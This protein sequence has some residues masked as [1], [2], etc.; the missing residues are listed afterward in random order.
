M[1]IT[2]LHINNIRNHTTTELEPDGELN[3]FYGLNGS[4]KTSVIEAISICGFTKSFMPCSDSSIIREGEESYLVSCKAINDYEIPYHVAV[5]YSTGKKKRINSTFGDNLNPKDIIGE[6]P[7]VILNPDYKMITFG[8][9]SDRRE[10]LD[11]LLSQAGKIYMEELIKMKKALKQRNSLLS[12]AKSGANVDYS[13]IEPWNDV[14][15]KSAAEI[16]IRRRNFIRDFIPY[17]QDVYNTIAGE[18][19]E[20][21]IDYLPDSLEGIDIN[22]T[23]P[24]EIEQIY[25]QKLKDRMREEFAR[26]VTSIGPQ[27]DELRITV[28]GRLA[29]DAAS[30]GQHKSL[31]ISIKFAEFNYLKS[32]KNET[33]LILLDDIFAELDKER[34]DKV[35]QLI[36]SHKAQTFITLTDKNHIEDFLGGISCKSFLVSGGKVK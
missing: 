7:M 2:K 22:S 24:K 26:G 4:G 34:A 16:I 33:P 32:R 17:F 19:E 35:I 25:L 10:F 30:Q 15:V 36:K 9:P 28:N 21:S 29:R 1:K 20:V 18:K 27:K 23:E 6:M 12:H 14:F 3:I 13:L 5:N 11:R 31:L 8:A